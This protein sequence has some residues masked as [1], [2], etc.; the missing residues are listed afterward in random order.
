[1][2]R[3]CE[4]LDGCW[5]SVRNGKIKSV[6]YIVV[7]QVPLQSVIFKLW[8]KIED[9]W[10]GT[11]VVVGNIKHQH[12]CWCLLSHSPA[13]VVG[14]GAGQCCRTGEEPGPDGIYLCRLTAFSDL[15]VPGRVEHGEPWGNCSVCYCRVRYF[16]LS[17]V[18]ILGS[19]NRSNRLEI[20][21]L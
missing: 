8:A 1:M 10:C 15:G 5:E 21:C 18:S 20:M 12:C 2:I 9:W 6:R 3:F 4:L 7:H 13:V 14:C 16:F 11:S 19:S 17:S